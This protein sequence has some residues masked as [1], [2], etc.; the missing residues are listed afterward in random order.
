MAVALL[1]A[2]AFAET[3]TVDDCVAFENGL[4]N[5]DKTCIK[6]GLLN[7]KEGTC[8]T[9]NPDRI[10]SPEW[11]NNDA[12]QT[13]WWVET[14]CTTHEEEVVV[15]VPPDPDSYILTPKCIAFENGQGHYGENCYNSGLLRMKENT[16]YTMNPARETPVYINNIATET[17]WWVE[18]D[19]F[20]TT[21]VSSSSEPESSSSSEPDPVSSAPESSSCG[22]PE[23]N[24]SC[25]EV[26]ESSSSSEPESSS[27]SEPESSSSS[28]PE[29]SSSSEPES[30]SSSV[31]YTNKCI[32]YVHGAGNYT[33]NCYISGLTGMKP[34]TC[35]KLNPE[36]VDVDVF[37]NTLYINGSAFDT[38][39]WEETECELVEVI[40]PPDPSTYTLKD[41]GCIEYK[42]HAGHYT[43]NCYN[44]GLTNMVEG[45]CYALNPARHKDYRD[46]DAANIPYAINGDAH[47]AYWWQET[48]CFDTIFVD[49]P[50]EPK[51]EPKAK[52]VVADNS[53]L[54]VVSAADVKTLRV[55]D[56]NG[57]LL[58]SETFTGMVKDVDYTKF[59]GKGVLLVRITSGNKLVAMK[60]VSV[61]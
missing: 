9:M 10:V 20:D 35:Y 2:A 42:H 27:S 8:Y 26:D 12:S 50:A 22:D 17:W 7:M 60:R 28:E 31:E 29:S 51:P 43:Q 32:N 21:F 44:A 53:S 25:G 19:C 24:G 38:Y 61:R 30:S 4:A 14:E 56:M 54:S 18:T 40:P 49:Q 45:K 58:H 15:V 59:A 46:A 1:A 6:S 48:P 13:W 11:I 16:C 34:G 37:E 36:R 39:W 47:E 23:A 5:Y 33:K 57:K 41:N 55:F 52:K 3:V